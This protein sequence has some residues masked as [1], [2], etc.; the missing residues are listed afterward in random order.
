MRSTNKKAVDH[1]MAK[2]G[3]LGADS[4]TG[5]IAQASRALRHAS[6]IPKPF[7]SRRPAKQSLL[8]AMTADCASY[9]KVM[10]QLLASIELMENALNNNHRDPS[11]PE[12]DF[13]IL[14]QTHMELYFEHFSSQERKAVI[15]TTRMFWEIYKEA[16]KL[17][18][19][20]IS[21]NAKPPV[22]TRP[23]KKS[24]AKPSKKQVTLTPKEREE[25]IK[26]I[27]EII[28]RE[29]FFDWFF[30]DTLALVG[31][32]IESLANAT[33]ALRERLIAALNEPP[34][35]P[36]VLNGRDR[37]VVVNGKT[38][39][40]LSVAQY[41]VLEALLKAGA[42]GLTGQRLVDSSGHG[43][44]VNVLKSLAKRDADWT[45]A[46]DLAG[47]PGRGYRVAEPDR[48]IEHP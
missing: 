19:V 17:T 11:P 7:P 46:I 32:G 14:Q 5:L 23:N 31:E 26:L 20:P 40:R 45:A 1:G 30:V 15:K 27:R 43:D 37:P 22:R 9:K 16:R 42:A 47:Q 12:V 25:A 8:N 13:T 39:G 18:H 41:N 33:I 44:A 35:R 24:K 4:I 10:L 28:N 34:P 21:K 48:P 29:D 3:L 2:R 6:P 38:K 36:L